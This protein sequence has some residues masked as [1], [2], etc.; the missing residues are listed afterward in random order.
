MKASVITLGCKVNE[1]ESQSI[2]NQLKSN[3][4]E[5]SE[6]LVYADVYVVNTCAVTNIAERKSRQV[7]SKIQKINKDAK[8]IVCGCASQNNPAKF[9]QNP[10]VFSVTGNAKKNEI[11]ELINERNTTLPKIEDKIYTNTA[12]P[13]E[14]RTRQFIKIQD[15]CDYFCT[16]CLIPYV[17]GR[18]RSRDIDDILDEI[19]HT[20]SN[21]IV[22]TG[23]NMTDYKIDGKLALKYLIKEV[24]KLNKRFRL[25]SIECMALDDEMIGILKNCKNFCP[26]LHI[27]LQS[28]CNETL[29]RMNRHYT[30]EQF[31]EKIN[32]LRQQFPNIC[33]S[34]DII[35]GFKGETDEE[36]ETTYNNLKKIKFSFMHIFPYSVR[37]GT[38]ASRLKGDVDKQV[39]KQREQKLIELNKKFKEEF[40]NNNKNT[41]HKVLI[42]EVV[43]ERF[44]LGY[45][46]NYIYTKIDEPLKIG[47]IY[48][49]ELVDTYNDGMIGVRR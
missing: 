43:D 42:E 45:T 5:I 21:E 47:E 8:I 26:H 9:L 18:S 38:V 10:N 23:I 34:T 3:G 25:S 36:F 12:R 46:D 33:L 20:T 24:D 35:V 2:L 13:I 41:I 49:I 22:L 7:L 17:R 4:Y 39:V 16:Y 14:T 29:R 28:A 44:S 11:M 30:I 19:K 37:E 32:K 27:S 31:M 40:Y 6:G 1:Y 48:N 15:G